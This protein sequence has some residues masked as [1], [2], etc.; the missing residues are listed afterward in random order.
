[1][2]Q[3]VEVSAMKLQRLYGQG[4]FPEPRLPCSEGFVPCLPV[5][6]LLMQP[7]CLPA[8]IAAAYA[9][10]T[11]PRYHS[12]ALVGTPGL[13]QPKVGA[14]IPPCRHLRGPI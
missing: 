8:W 5:F 9:A 12:Q 4:Q 2:P 3:C 11:T 6:G 10:G 1:M 14:E 13:K 7:Q